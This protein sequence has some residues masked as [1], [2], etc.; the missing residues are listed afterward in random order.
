MG[1]ANTN[2]GGI[3]YIRIK[4]RGRKLLG[5]RGAPPGLRLTYMYI[6]RCSGTPQWQPQLGNEV[7][8]IVE[9]WPYIHAYVP[10]GCFATLQ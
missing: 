3:P 8:A 4:G 2:P 1:V 5:R 9:R 6:L 10:Q 7:W